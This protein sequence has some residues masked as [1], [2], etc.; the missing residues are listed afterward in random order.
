[1]IIIQ[2]INKNIIAHETTL[3]KA[4][5]AVSLEKKKYK[6]LQRKVSKCK[7]VKYKDYFWT[8]IKTKTK[9]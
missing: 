8:R 4:M 1:M 7:T 5:K 6:Y 9:P 3:T 2:D